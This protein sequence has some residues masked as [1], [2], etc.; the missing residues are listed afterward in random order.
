MRAEVQECRHQLNG[1]R[2]FSL[3][4]LQSRN[5]GMSS[6]ID[7]REDEHYSLIFNLN[8]WKIAMSVRNERK[9]SARMKH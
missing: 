5:S 9:M 3:L 2:H 1:E 4:D 7:K 6:T 8:T